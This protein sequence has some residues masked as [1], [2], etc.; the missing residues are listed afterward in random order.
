M[1][2]G[3][4]FGDLYLFEIT[5]SEGEATRSYPKYKKTHTETSLGMGSL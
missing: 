1:D 2:F 5:G 4:Y 3:L